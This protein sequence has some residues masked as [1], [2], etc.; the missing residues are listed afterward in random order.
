LSHESI[1]I[2]RRSKHIDCAEIGRKLDMK[3]SAVRVK[4]EKSAQDSGADL[5][6]LLLML[7]PMR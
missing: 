6:W 5:I 3:D 4:K 7:I 1:V 2:D